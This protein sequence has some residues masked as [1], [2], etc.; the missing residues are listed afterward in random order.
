MIHR[1]CD[2]TPSM[3]IFN[4]FVVVCGLF[5]K[6]SFRNTIFRVLN[7]LDPDQDRRFVG[8]DLDPNCFQKV[9]SR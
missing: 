8:P 4:A 3:V 1:I 9:I 7:I 2:F 6:N 5:S